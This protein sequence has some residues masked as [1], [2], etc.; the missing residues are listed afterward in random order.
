MFALG[1][2]HYKRKG[3][4]SLVAISTSNLWLVHPG[5]LAPLVWRCWW[6]TP[7]QS[8]ITP[9]ASKICQWIKQQSGMYHWNLPDDVTLS[10]ICQHIWVI[11]HS[12]CQSQRSGMVL[13]VKSLIWPGIMSLRNRV[14]VDHDDDDDER[15]GCGE[16]I[17][18]LLVYQTLYCL[19]GF[20]SQTS[21]D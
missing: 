6:F 21:V 16:K 18:I 10:E 11:Q 1:I 8:L 19:A 3:S 12:W 7:D 20:P 2:G 5:L 13:I 17:G 14:W 15:L 4:C 9:P